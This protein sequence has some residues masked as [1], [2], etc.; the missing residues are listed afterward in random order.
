MKTMILA[1][2]FG[3]RLWPLTIGRTKPAIPFLNRPLI[4]Y[5]IEYLRSY[6]LDDLIINLHHE[7]DSV[8]SQIG[9]GEQYGVKL[10]YS[11]E[12]PEIL[13]TAGALDRVREQLENETFVVINGQ[14]ITDL[15]LAAAIERHRNLQALATLVLIPN[16]NYE[17]FSEVHVNPDGRILKFGNFPHPSSFIPD[18]SSSIPHPLMFTGIHILEPV[19]FD[20]IPRGIFSDSVRDIYPKAMAKGELIGAHITRGS[21]YELSTIERYLIISLEFLQ[22]EGRSLLMDEGCYIDPGARVERSILWKNVRVE[23]GAKLSECV[24]GDRVIIPAG[25]EFHRAAIVRAG[26]EELRERPEKSLPGELFGENLVVR[27]G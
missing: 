9:D 26:P 21:W 13:G 20:Y 8:R 6:G 22:R 1:A 10:S 16:Q 15:D 17:G 2:G 3:T 23:D 25:A 24:I 19:I 11:V 12:E 5:T 27:I 14:I 7:P 18:P 4:A